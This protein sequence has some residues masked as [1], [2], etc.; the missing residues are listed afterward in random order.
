MSRFFITEPSNSN[1]D[2]LAE[3][4]DEAE[5]GDGGI[6]HLVQLVR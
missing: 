4:I 6:R 2:I 3:F 1:G 5:P